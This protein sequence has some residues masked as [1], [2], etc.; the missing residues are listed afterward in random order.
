MR[1]PVLLVIL[2]FPIEV[3][4]QEPPKHTTTIDVIAVTPV[5]GIGL[6][7]DKF[8]TNAQRIVRADG[9]EVSDSL[10]RSGAGT[11]LNNPAGGP[12]QSDLQFR[13][14]S[15]SSLLGASQ[16][17]ALFQDGVRLNE[18]FGDT[19]A[20]STVPSAAIESIEVTPG[21]NAVF[22]LNALGGALT[23]RTR[24]SAQDS[25]AMLRAGSFGRA[26]GEIATGGEQWFLSASHLRDGGW[27][28]FS[29][30]DAT[31]LFASAR[32]RSGDARLTLA[33]SM[34]T[35]NGAAPEELLEVRRAEVF[36]HPDE[37]RN[38]T[39]MLSVTQHRAIRGSLLAQGLGYVR[40]T[41]TRTFNGDDSPYDHCGGFLCLEDELVRDRSGAPIPLGGEELDATNNRSQLEQT[42]FGASVQLDGSGAIAGRA[43]RVL[44]GIS[45]DGGTARFESSTEIANLNDDRG[46][47][48]IGAYDAASFVELTTRSRTIS[49]FAADIL[50]LTAR[51]TITA[52]ARLNHVRMRLDD[53]IGTALDGDHT[54][55]QAHPSLGAALELAPS[56]SAFA[57]VGF[58]GR[59]PTP[60]ELSCADP[61]DPCRL[62]NAFVSDPPLRA[63]RSRTLEAGL[64]GTTPR[65]TWSAAVHHSTSDDDLLFISSG[66]LRGEGHF[67]NVGKTRRRG[68]EAAAEGRVANRVQWSASYAFLDATFASA[69]TVAAPN[70]PF[71]TGEEIEVQRGDRLPLVPRHVLKLDANA[72]V[73]SR[74]RAGASVRA[75]SEQYLRGDEGNLAEPLPAYVVA[76]A[77]AEYVLT[78]R[79]R[80]L[81]D[82][83]NVFDAE[84]ETFGTFG[85]AEDVL[86]EEYEDSTRFVTPAAPR[87]F[88]LAV[89]LRF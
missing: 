69:F 15:V 77:R 50:T 51:V 16:G 56:V 5:D 63:V 8:P 31:Q 62:P 44:G 67:A 26:E 12:L 49:A 57:N 81:L 40:R 78:D 85:D 66:P 21:A 79:V 37:T 65:I 82:V 19:I 72:G 36:T 20:W 73:T 3:F 4:A 60:V 39:A 61:E 30:S 22:G 75:T 10:L 17:L 84:Y 33:R 6:D 46:T 89:A 25:S 71:A 52:T 47:S 54:F 29:P 74:L 1:L 45:I 41:R 34:L 38:Q 13:G 70:H 28:D 55:T 53:R 24:S 68:L 9:A 87:L 80:L 64:R 43:N 14:F 18:P 27:R 86:G 83:H 35:G 88:G 2:V 76:D 32:W 7:R 58:A 59:T 11:E 48:G 42:A 23:L